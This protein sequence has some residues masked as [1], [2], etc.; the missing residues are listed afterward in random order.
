[1]NLG[2]GR[3]PGTNLWQVS[4]DTVVHGF[5]I[6]WG[7]VSLTVILFNGHLYIEKIMKLEDSHY[8]IVNLIIKL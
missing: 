7:S 2:I 1:M 3:G 5:S 6:V 4:R 8:L